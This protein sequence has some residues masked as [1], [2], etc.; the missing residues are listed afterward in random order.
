MKFKAT[1]LV[2]GIP[3]LIYLHKSGPVGIELKT[4]TGILSPDQKKIHATWEANGIKVY[5]CRSFEQFQEIINEIHS[6]FD[7]GK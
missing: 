2:S 4:E 3:D 6:G 1:G 5:V 7:I